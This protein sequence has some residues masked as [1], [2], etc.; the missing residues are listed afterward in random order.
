MEKKF[1]PNRLSLARQ[2]RRLT[3]KA[4]AEVT[5]LSPMAISRIEN[6]S[7]EVDDETLE[8]LSA[9]LRYPVAF[10]Y[11]KDPDSIDTEAVSFRS[12]SK[13]S[14]K[15]KLSAIAAGQLG[16]ELSNWLEK[17]FSLPDP[18]LIDL[19]YEADPEAAANALRAYWNL[20]QKPIS[21]MIGLLE[22]KGV[23]V[24]SLAE[25]TR[26]VDAFSF[27]RDERPF[28]YLNNYKTAEHSIFDAAH[29]LGHLVMHRHAGVR[30]GEQVSRSTERE[31]NEFASAFLMP[32]N[33]VI[34]RTPSFVSVDTIIRL[35]ARWRV[36]AMAMAYR[37]HRL[38]RL[39]EWQYKSACIELGRR[40]Y[41]TGEPIG[42]ERE[43]SAVW[44]KVLT[45]LW[46][47][48]KSKNYIADQINLPLDEL[49]ALIWG[50]AGE[51]HKPERGGNPLSIVK[52]AD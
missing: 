7:S 46:S 4:L 32:K 31:A 13:M 35:K 52:P 10:F 17:E 30:P 50:L 34:S 24:F 37:L 5:G 43:T 1:N 41:R 15:E 48:R 33:D 36:S 40:G 8:V 6:G 19:S 20:G 18:D 51:A 45:A 23:R 16:L 29:E 39:T 26:T 2:R 42:I 25:A 49:E 9:A 14:A 21:N 28:V 22:V 3:G 12:L 38:T 44:R 27:W 11:S 47:D